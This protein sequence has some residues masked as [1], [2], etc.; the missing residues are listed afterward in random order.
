MR[1]HIVRSTERLRRGLLRFWTD[2]R[3]AR[4]EAGAVSCCNACSRS[5]RGWRR[6]LGCYGAIRVGVAAES[7]HAGSRRERCNAE[8]SCRRRQAGGERR[9]RRLGR[10]GQRAR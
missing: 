4:V 10:S 2:K 3:A 6:I 7:G 8:C 5:V 1:S 9:V